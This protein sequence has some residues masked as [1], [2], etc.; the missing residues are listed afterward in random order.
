V[1]S[2]TA[3]GSSPPT[4]TGARTSGRAGYMSPPGWNMDLAQGPEDL[5]TRT[6]QA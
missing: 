1:H 2:H 6:T 4:R 3:P 5:Q